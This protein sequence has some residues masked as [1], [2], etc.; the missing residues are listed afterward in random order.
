MIAADHLAHLL[1]EP[2]SEVC[3]SG[4]LLAE[5]LLKAQQ[6]YGSDFIIVFADVSVEVEAMGV[7]LEYLPDRNPQP[8]KQLTWEEIGRVDMTVEGRLPELFH[9]AEIC[10]QARG[11]DFTIFFSMKDPF[12]LAAMTLGT[13]AFLEKLLLDPDAVERVLE[14]CCRNQQQLMSAV[15]KAG[16]IP[17][18]GAPIAS[19]GL[20]G[21]RNFRRFALP[22]LQRLFDMATENGSFGCLHIC[23][24]IAMLGSELADLKLDLLSF[25]DWKEDM[26]EDLPETIPMGFIPT[27]LFVRGSAESV[28]EAARTSRGAMLQPYV[29]STGCDL[30]A[31]AD[32]KLVQAMMSH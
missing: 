2:L 18:V 31:N 4:E 3:H 24:E 20:I 12:S 22:Y 32:P 14:I 19:G 8:V 25:E 15:L 1:D 21:K 11:G 30:P 23:G 27:D 26:W 6:L 9:A 7:K 13:E 5:G 10:R 28:R 29:L 17:F 16:F